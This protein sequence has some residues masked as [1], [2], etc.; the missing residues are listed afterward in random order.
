M[1]EYAL[2]TQI[3]SIFKA[4]FGD[5][6]ALTFAVAHK[7]PDFYLRK[8]SL[9]PVLRIEMKS[10]DAESDEQAAKFET[11]TNLIK[12]DTDF[13]L[14]AAWE[15]KEEDAGNK[16]FEHPHIFAHAF[17]SASEIADERDR[18][19]RSKGG[20]IRSGKVYVPSTKHK[21]KLGPDP[22]NYGK[23]WRIVTKDR[24]EAADLSTGARRFV[25]FL[26]EV[27]QHSPRKRM[28]DAQRSRLRGQG[29]SED[30]P[31]PTSASTAL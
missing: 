16:K 30:V 14:F 2:C 28:T 26:A 23:L 10:V 27:D 6:A 12:E 19:L 7:Y 1:L 5:G 18:R 13:I 9:Q 3:D 21:G 31:K 20:R 25:Q 22:R 24:W 11:A 4:E 15:W 17:V 29:L 8:K